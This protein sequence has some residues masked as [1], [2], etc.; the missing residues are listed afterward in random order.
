MRIRYDKGDHGG[1]QPADEIHQSGA[2]EVAHAFHVAHDARHQHAGLVGIVVGDGQAADVLLHPAAQFGDQ[3][4]R[5]FGKRLGERERG[6]ALHQCGRQHDP[7]QRI[8]QP[9][10]ALADDVV[11]QVL[12]R[13]GQNQ[14]GDAVDDHQPEA[15]QHQRAAGAD[16]LPDF[17]QGFEYLGLLGRLRRRTIHDRGSLWIH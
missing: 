5:C 2:D 1:Q 17:R 11:N 3:F 15:E 10:M 14:A 9:E 16:E 12:G 13:I 4:L 6:Q 7:D 8:E